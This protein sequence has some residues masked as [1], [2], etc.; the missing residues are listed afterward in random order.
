MKSPSMPQPAQLMSRETWGRSCPS[1]A[2]SSVKAAPEVRSREM[3]L[4]E[5]PGSCLGQRLEPVGPAGDEP[6]AADV[7]ELCLHLADELPA[8]AGGR[9]GNNRG[10]HCACSFCSDLGQR[11]F[12]MVAKKKTVA[13]STDRK[14]DTGSARKTA[15]TLSSKKWGRI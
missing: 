3:V 9:A 4:T 7:R 10:F 1:R 13:V 5:M 11:V 12:R 8:E 2:S 14:S 6:I 15:K